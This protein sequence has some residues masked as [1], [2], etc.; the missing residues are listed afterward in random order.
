MGGIYMRCPCSAL[1]GCVSVTA[2]C[3]F[4]S[5]G[6]P[7]CLVWWHRRRQSPAL[8][9]SKVHESS[10]RSAG[11][12]NPLPLTALGVGLLKV[13][14]TGHGRTLELGG[15][16]IMIRASSPSCSLCLARTL[17]SSWSW[18]LALMLILYFVLSS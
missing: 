14:R 10:G 8:C 6:C 11:V 16:S 9:F 12:Q 1:T 17:G 3:H 7:L 5:C 15:C 13:P 2:S 4:S 18:V